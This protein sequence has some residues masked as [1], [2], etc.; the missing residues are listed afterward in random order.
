MI[1][2]YIYYNKLIIDE[3]FCPCKVCAKFHMCNELDLITE[4]HSDQLTQGKCIL[5]IELNTF[6]GYHWSEYLSI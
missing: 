5:N 1:Y 3:K 6:A 2:I 4:N